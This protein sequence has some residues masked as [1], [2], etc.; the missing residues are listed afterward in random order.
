M[1][2]SLGFRVKGLLR[3]WDTGS[4]VFCMSSLRVLSVEMPT[5]P[6]ISGLYEASEVFT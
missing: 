2:Y 5:S 1:D 4:I 3:V 6:T